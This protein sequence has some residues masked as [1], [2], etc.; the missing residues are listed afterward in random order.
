[1]FVEQRTDE[2]LADRVGRITASRFKAVLARL[3]NG[4]PAQARNDYLMD[5][6]CER[7]TGQPTH[8]FVNQAMQ[9][10]IDQE[11]FAREAYEQ[12]TGVVV[13]KA[14]FIILDG[15][16]ASAGA[17]PDGLVGAGCIEIK[18]PNT[19][20]HVQTI[21]DGMP[22]EH[23]AQVQGVM[24]A[25]GSD[26]CDF[27]SW[28]PRVPGEHQLYIERIERDDAFIEMLKREIE[29]FDQEVE[30]TIQKLSESKE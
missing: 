27:I 30:A 5:V 8:H 22:D 18:A 1:M 21:L 2:W 28:D 11:E 3:K 13:E 16:K 9:W 24:L 15:I 12:R 23:Y 10:G 25:T 6:V 14:G 4:Q 26:W 29:V 19:R 20:T 7:L 17:S